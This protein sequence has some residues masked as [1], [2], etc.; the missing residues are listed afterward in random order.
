MLQKFWLLT[1]LKQD[2]ALSQ[3]YLMHS[4]INYDFAI[5]RKNQPAHSLISSDNKCIQRHENSL[6]LGIINHHLQF[7]FTFCTCNLFTHFFSCCFSFL[8]Y[9]IYFG[10]NVVFSNVFFFKIFFFSFYVKSNINFT[11][12][13]PLPVN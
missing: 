7:H 13:W 6:L 8:K 9:N 4:I 2:F 10:I 5:K 1:N 11:R 3:T 12:V